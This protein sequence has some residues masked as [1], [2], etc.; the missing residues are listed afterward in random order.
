M[1]IRK[2]V[3]CSSG[4]CV[5]IGKAGVSAS[6]VNLGFLSRR[7]VEVAESDERKKESDQ[8]DDPKGEFRSG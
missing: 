3:S 5:E 4:H 6:G 1:G 8:R 2:R 7:A